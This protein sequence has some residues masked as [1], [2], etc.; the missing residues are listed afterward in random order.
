MRSVDHWI[1]RWPYQSMTREA[2]G[3]PGAEDPFFGVVI[4]AIDVDSVGVT[5]MLFVL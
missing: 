5:A 1:L 3:V 4:D 2:Y